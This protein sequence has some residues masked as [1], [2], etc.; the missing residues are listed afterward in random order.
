ME[1]G[2]TEVNIRGRKSSTINVVI[3]VEVGR[4]SCDESGIEDW[5]RLGRILCSNIVF[6]LKFCSVWVVVLAK[7]C[8]A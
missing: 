4:V 8:R 7:S 6:R 5:L 1:G 3:L 2:L